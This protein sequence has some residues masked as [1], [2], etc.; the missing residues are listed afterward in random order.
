MLMSPSV[1]CC[2]LQQHRQQRLRVPR[3]HAVAATPAAAGDGAHLRQQAAQVSVLLSH[4]VTSAARVHIARTGSTGAG[5]GQLA[6]C[7]AQGRGC[8]HG[9]KRKAVDTGSSLGQQGGCLALEKDLCTM[10]RGPG[11]VGEYTPALSHVQTATAAQSV[12]V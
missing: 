10:T 6:S 7:P 12:F 4:C 5:K 9:R 2:G 3:S 8:A 1:M 11:S